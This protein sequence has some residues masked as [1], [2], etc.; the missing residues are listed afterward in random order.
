[1]RKLK[2][3]NGKLSD[4]NSKLLQESAE[5]LWTIHSLVKDYFG[6]RLDNEE[7]HVLGI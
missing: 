2:S 1:M 7:L 6:D 3:L 5:K 4:A